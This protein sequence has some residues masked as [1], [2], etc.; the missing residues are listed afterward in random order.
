MTLLII[1]SLIAIIFLVGTLLS[2]LLKNVE[3]KDKLLLLIEGSIFSTALIVIGKSGDTSN[4]FTSI[5]LTGIVLLLLSFSV[6]L[7]IFIQKYRK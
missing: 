7:H 5:Q 1:V 4:L 3:L 2:I 6:F